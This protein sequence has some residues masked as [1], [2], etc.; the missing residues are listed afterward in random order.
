MLQPINKLPPETLSHIA[1]WILNPTDEDVKLIIPLTHVCRYWRNSIISAPGN[2]TRI[3]SHR[4]PI[5]ALSLERSKA[6]PLKISLSMDEVGEQSG[7][8]GLLAPY[9]Q[10]IV[11]LNLFGLRTLEDLMRTLPNFPR[12]TPNLRSLEILLEDGENG[13]DIS[14]DP[15]QPFPSTLRHLILFDIP[16]Y[17]AFLN[18]RTLTEFTLCDYAFTLPLDTLLTML[19]ENHLLE[20]VELSIGFTSPNLHTSQGRAPISNRFQHLS[21]SFYKVEDARPLISSIPIQRGANLELNSR[22]SIG[23]LSDILSSISATHLANLQSPTY[24]EL[25]ENDIRLSGPNGSFSF[26]GLSPS[27]M[28]LSRLPLLSFDKIRELHLGHPASR[29]KIKLVRFHPSLFP[30]LETL[31][32]EH[33]TNVLKTLSIWLSS[34]KSSPL[35]KTLAFLNCD[36]PEKFIKAL[37]TFACDRRK[38]PVTWLYRVLIVNR[39]G[40]FPSPSSLLGLMNYVKVVDFQIADRLPSDFFEGNFWTKM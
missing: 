30:V 7:F 33:D 32:V 18:L 23:G 22:G 26:S 20:R 10:N 35:L 9:I 6:A 25:C 19:E 16:L 2:W 24:M 27:E 36:L 4:E 5:A 21:V 15:F 37:T 38:A 40:N 28:S 8:S 29:S 14:I 39:R 13:L 31:A 12:S 17:P 34:P 3:S 11:T 1:R